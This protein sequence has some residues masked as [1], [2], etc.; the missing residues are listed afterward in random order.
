MVPQLPTVLSLMNAGNPTDEVNRGVQLSLLAT[1]VDV[2]LFALVS[3]DAYRP[4]TRFIIHGTKHEG[5]QKLC[6][7]IRSMIPNLFKR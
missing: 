4:I 3:L 2:D 6:T 5:S 7:F 1:G